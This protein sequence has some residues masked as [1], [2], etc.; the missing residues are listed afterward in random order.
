MS[1]DP[2]GKRP[3]H[4]G[5]SPELLQAAQQ[6]LLNPNL[7]RIYA[8]GFTLGFTAADVTVFLQ[9]NHVPLAAVDMAF[10]TVK[11]LVKSLSGM[12]EAYEKVVGTPIH[13]AEELKGAMVQLSEEAKKNVQSR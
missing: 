2:T 10:P 1:D 6:A 3:S 7:P 13:T 4:P 12:I 9:I 5:P 11:A 8:N